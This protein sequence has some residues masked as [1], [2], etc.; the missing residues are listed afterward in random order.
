MNELTI[1]ELQANMQ[2]GELTAHAITETY[3]RRIG[4]IDQDGP[5]LNS[6]IEVN[7]DAL[8]SPTRS[9][10]SAGNAAPAARSTASRC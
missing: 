9:T 3:L 4:E 1:A 2:T 6:V 8:E 10:P 7:P 5:R